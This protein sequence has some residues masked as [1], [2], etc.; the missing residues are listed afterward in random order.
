MA[1]GYPDFFGVSVFRQYG[2]FQR[3]GE[4][5]ALVPAGDIETVLTITGKGEIYFGQITLGGIDSPELVIPKIT[6]DGSEFSLGT[7]FYL[8][9]MGDM[10]ANAYPVSCFVYDT[11][12]N[13]YALALTG[14][15]TFVDSYVISIQNN[16]GLD[17]SVDAAIGWSQVS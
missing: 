6:I 15:I 11:E 4:D 7:L 17:C 16:D 9:S 5:L 14:G 13:Q 3:K 8:H 12:Y 2:S 10:K 1:K